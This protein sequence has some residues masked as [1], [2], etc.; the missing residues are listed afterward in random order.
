MSQTTPLRIGRLRAIGLFAEQEMTLAIRSR[1]TQIFAVGFAALALAVAWSGYV[2]SGGSGVQDFARTAASMIQL[3]LLLVPLAALGIGVLSLSDERGSAQLV[4]SQPVS[5]AEV[6]VGR[7]FGLFVALVAAQGIGFGIA[8]IVIF[9]NVGGEEAT[10]FL[11]VF[12]ASAIL[13]AIFTAIAA[14]L[15]AVSPT[16]SR[17]RA[18]ALALIAWFA[19]AVLFDI[20]ILGLSTFL[21]SGHASRLMIVGVIVNPI[22]AIRTGTMMAIQGTS[23]FGSAS[24]AF[25]RFTRGEPRAFAYLGLALTC[26]LAGPLAI[27]IWRLRRADL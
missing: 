9:S 13:T 27:A 16:Q 26:W 12:V 22:D 6:L 14:A 25:F 11:I 19:L 7:M 1:W 2:L 21:P 20:A 3:V 5:R 15:S 10:D 24:L 17:A 8:G 4:F 23:A 18:V